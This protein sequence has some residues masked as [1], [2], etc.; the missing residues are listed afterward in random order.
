VALEALACQTPVITTKIVGV[1]AD[2]E[3]VK[4]GTVVPSKDP[5]KLAA[6]TMELLEDDKMQK[7][8]GIKGRKLVEEKYTWQSVALK[9]EKLYNSIISNRI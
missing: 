2:L 6:A 5:E 9:M 8:M 1:A 7:G 3:K 4:A